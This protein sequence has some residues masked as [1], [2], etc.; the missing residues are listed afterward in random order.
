[1]FRWIRRL[2]VWGLFGLFLFAIAAVYSHKHI[3][4]EAAHFLFDSV[5]SIPS[6]K[7]ALVL[8]TAAKTRFGLENYFFSNRMAKA[9]ELYHSGK[10]KHLILSGDNHVKGYD[11][12]EDMRL[13][14]IALGVPDS[15]LHLD[16]AGFRTLDSIVRAKEVFGQDELIIVSQQFHNE[17]A[18]YLAQQNGLKVYGI[19]AADVPQYSSYFSQFRE[20]LAR[21]K[22]LL[23]IHVLK[24]QPHF[25][26]EKIT[27]GN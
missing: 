1:M 2:I 14:L 21:G 19:N 15:C 4:K 23:D 13:A 16:Y 24:T 26:G 20:Y 5:D 6:C 18:I 10:V 8:G 25:L 11:E 22:A 3:A 7:T 12:P 17:R 9:A 27:I